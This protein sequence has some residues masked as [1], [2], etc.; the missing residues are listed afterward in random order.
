[1]KKYKVHI[2]WVIVAV[3]A[4]AGGFFWGKSMAPAATGFPG[5][6]SFAGASGTRT[7]A[8]GGAAAGAGGGLV[9]GQVLSMSGDSMTVQLTNGNSQVVFYSSSTSVIKPEPAPVSALTPGTSVMIVGT[10]NSDGS[11]TAQSIQVRTASSTGGFGG[12][13]GGGGGTGSGSGTG[14]SA[15]TSGQ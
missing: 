7:F 10:T 12:G 11:L 9:T 8:R 6:G 5:G 2:I 15:N 14:A 3:V 1:M 4:L 13:A